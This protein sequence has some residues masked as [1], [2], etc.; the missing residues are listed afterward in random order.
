MSALKRTQCE[1]AEAEFLFVD[2]VGMTSSTKAG[3]HWHEWP[4]ITVDAETS[5]KFFGKSLCLHQPL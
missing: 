2:I 4:R 5:I 1:W 3:K